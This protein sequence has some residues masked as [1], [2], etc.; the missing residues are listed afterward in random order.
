LLEINKKENLHG[1]ANIPEP[2][3]HDI[4]AIIEALTLPLFILPNVRYDQV[5]FVT[6]MN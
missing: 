6:F 5:F 2:M 4:R 3:A 1:K